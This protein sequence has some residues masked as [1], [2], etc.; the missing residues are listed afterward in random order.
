M[1]KINQFINISIF[2]VIRD[3]QHRNP[4][5]DNKDNLVGQLTT[6]YI[7]MASSGFFDRLPLFWY[8]VPYLTRSSCEPHS[9][10]GFARFLRK[11]SVAG[12]GFKI[13]PPLSNTSIVTPHCLSRPQPPPS[14]F[15][16]AFSSSIWIVGA[17]SSSCSSNWYA[18]ELGVHHV[19]YTVSS[20]TSHVCL[21]SGRH[22]TDTRTRYTKHPSKTER[23]KQMKHI[24]HDVKL[25]K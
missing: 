18:P 1:D 19:L 4:N 23:Q 8:P 22:D 25:Y 11:T 17:F 2:F 15:S 21:Y 13:Y 3:D 10:A 20:E 9:Q 16:S 12:S 14:S 24:D 7:I 5:M 6:I